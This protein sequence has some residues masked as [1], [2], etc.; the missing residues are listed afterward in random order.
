[1]SHRVWVWALS[2]L[3]TACLVPKSQLEQAQARYQDEVTAHAA[4]Q[5]QLAWTNAHLHETRRTVAVL[6]ESARGSG[7]ELR[8]TQQSLAATEFQVERS[9]QAGLEAHQLVEQLTQ[10][11]HRTG[12]HVRELVAERDGLLAERDA[13][14]AHGQH[15]RRVP[16]AAE[17]VD[18]T[19]ALRAGL[20]SRAVIATDLDDGLELTFS[21]RALFRTST[22]TELSKP[23]ERLLSAMGEVLASWSYG[24]TLVSP[25]GGN[26]KRA[27]V[28]SSRLASAGIVQDRIHIASPPSEE[29]CDLALRIA[30]T[31]PAAALSTSTNASSTEAATTQP[32]ATSSPQAP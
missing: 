27:A 11:L 14:A 16:S 21:Q 29:D 15:S 17:L 6:E 31:P 32:A 25:S 13:L 5:R 18:L 28:V 4:S 24:I 2:P 22:G 20:E 9:E 30:V 19:L 23:G 3:A 12:R 10:D 7:E 26:P 8:A 1:M